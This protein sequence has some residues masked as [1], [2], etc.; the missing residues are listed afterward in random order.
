MSTE[1]GISSIAGIHPT[2]VAFVSM[3]RNYM[4]DHA[5]LN[6]LVAGQES[7]DRMVL[8]AVMDAV[9]RYNGTPPETYF[10]LSDLFQKNRQPLLLRMTVITLLESLCLLQSRNHIN[11]STGGTSVGVSDKTPLLMNLIQYFRS[12]TDQD[13]LRAKVSDNILSILGHPGVHSEYW[14][15]HSSYFFW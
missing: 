6:R 1:T 8:F 2:T 7:S 4:R 5:A 13:L 14:T 9:A 3:V 11:Y 12:V 10:G 15:I